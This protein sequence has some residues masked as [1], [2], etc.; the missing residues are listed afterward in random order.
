MKDR[1]PGGQDNN[2]TFRRLR[3]A[4]LIALGLIAL[5]VLTEQLLVGSFLNDQRQ[6]AEIIN[7]AGRQRMLSQRIVKEIA[8]RGAR[9]AGAKRGME[10]Q[11]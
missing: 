1:E 2:E 4:Y 8:T 9:D 10:E 6:D 11:A 5:A 3:R 7:V